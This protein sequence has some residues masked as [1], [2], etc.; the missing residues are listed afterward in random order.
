MTLLELSEKLERLAGKLP[1]PLRKPLLREITPVKDL[2]LKQRSPKLLFLGSRSVDKEKLIN[3]LF[4][5]EVALSDPS[6]AGAGSWQTFSRRGQGTLRCLDARN[7]ANINRIK[8]S[9]AMELPDAV[10][11]LKQREI[12][13]EAGDSAETVLGFIRERSELSLPIIGAVVFDKAGEENQQ[14]EEALLRNW[15]KPK[16]ELNRDLVGVFSI[17]LKGEQNQKSES[18]QPPEE[19]AKEEKSRKEIE[20][21]AE[22]IT[23]HLPDDAKLEMARLSGVHSAQIHIAQILTRSFSAISGAIGA[24]PIPLADFP[25]LTSIQA[26]M[27]GGIMYVSGREVTM[28]LAAEFIAALGA[29]ISAGL[30]LRESARALLKLFPGWGNAISGAIASAGTYAIGRAAS[31]YFIQGVSLPDARKLFRRG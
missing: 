27:V 28:K 12:P 26:V 29:N 13:P 10:L 20:L 4:G 11:F 5:Y 15:F 2:F 8:S 3:A 7:P 6:E 17:P 31:A 23:Q 18:E 24:Q 16:T 22:A 14:S 9:L 19:E 25:I 1:G 21:F 30:V